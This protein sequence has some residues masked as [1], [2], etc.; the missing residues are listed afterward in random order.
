MSANGWERWGRCG[1]PHGGSGSGSGN[2]HGFGR[3]HGGRG[4]PGVG[5]TVGFSV[6]DLQVQT[7]PRWM[8]PGKG[9][10]MVTGTAGP[11]AGGI[12]CGKPQWGG[13]SG[14]LHGK[15]GSGLP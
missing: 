15:N 3:A 12:G 1:K 5:R 10:G 8:A 7:F 2:P 14:G 4:R 11:H 9:N 13:K 6:M